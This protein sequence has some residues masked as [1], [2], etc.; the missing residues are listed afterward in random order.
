MRS[1]GNLR[2]FL[3]C[4]L[5]SLTPYFIYRKLYFLYLNVFSLVDRHP[6]H[7]IWAHDKK[8]KPSYFSNDDLKRINCVV[9][10]IQ[11]YTGVLI[12]KK[13]NWQLNVLDSTVHQVDSGNV[14]RQE[15]KF[16][17]QI[18]S[19]ALLRS[20]YYS[21]SSPLP[22]GSHEIVVRMRTS[23]LSLARS[24]KKQKCFSSVY[25]QLYRPFLPFS[26]Q[27]HRNTV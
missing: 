19:F 20:Y 7:G 6:W 9:T 16:N 24:G 4:Q 15:N 3:F 26:R 14:V 8:N 17:W 10:L 11:I 5:Y 1:V 13:R 22:Q 25:L 2:I 18:N 27:I 23:V 12:F 21:I